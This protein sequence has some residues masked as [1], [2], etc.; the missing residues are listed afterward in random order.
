MYTRLTKTTTVYGTSNEERECVACI[1]HGTEKC[2][3]HK[4]IPNCMHCDVFAAILNQLHAF[5]DM[6]CEE[7]QSEDTEID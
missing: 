7:C 3:I 5:E 1:Y 4:G 6:L 2:R